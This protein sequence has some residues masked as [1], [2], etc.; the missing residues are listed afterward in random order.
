MHLFALMAN[1]RFQ[2]ILDI[3][4]LSVVAYH[5]YLWFQGTK[6]FKALVGLLGF[7]M[8]YTI[9]QS[10]GLFLTTWVFQVFWQVLVILLIIL[11]QSEIRQVLERANPLSALGLRKLSKPEHWIPEFSKAI[12]SLAKRKIGALVIIER[13]DMVENMVTGGQALDGE[14]GPELLMSIF[15]KESP[16]H[17][18]AML[19]RKGRIDQVACYLPLSADEGLPKEWG[20]RHRAAL[21]ITQRCDACVVAVSEER[22]KVSFARGKKVSPVDDAEMLSNWLMEAISPG[23]PE[24]KSLLEKAFSIFHH[25]WPIKISTLVLV[26]L[27]WL[28]LAGQQNF[29]VAIE[30]PVEIKNIPANI[31]R[32]EAT[33]PQV[34]ITVRGL[35]KDASTLDKSDVHAGIDL[36]SARSGIQFFRITRDQI[37]L[38]NDRLHV[39]EI[40]P[41]ILKFEFQEKP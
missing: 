7:G 28:L 38:P 18:G 31:E 29:E 27:V 10:W 20:T 19:I 3:L 26:G 21:G 4:F 39:I 40:V 2:D 12:F 8:I 16:L 5:L 6:A 35:R 37:V 34:K 17:D 9:A 33:N 22:G 1:L 23:S 25:R 41:S 24:K 36:S 32:L 30:I 14:P 15:H 11:F 13:M